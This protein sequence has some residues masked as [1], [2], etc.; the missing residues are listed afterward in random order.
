MKTTP[1]I[2]TKCPR[3]SGKKFKNCHGNKNNPSA[4][5]MKFE[6]KD[7]L[8]KKG[9][10][11]W[12]NGVYLFGDLFDANENYPFR[13]FV[14]PLEN[15]AWRLAELNWMRQFKHINNGVIAQALINKAAALLKT[16]NLWAGEQTQ[17]GA[18]V[19]INQKFVPDEAITS[20]TIS[21]RSGLLYMPLIQWNNLWDRIDQRI[22]AD[23]Y[24]RVHGFSKE[25]VKTAV[26]VLRNIFPSNWVRARYADASTTN[27][28]PRMGDA[29]PPEEKNSWFPAYHLA[30]TALGAICVDPGW[31]YLVE[32]GL[33]IKDL[34][35]FK[36]TKKILKNLTKSPG[37]QHHLCLAS[38]LYKRG[39]LIGL[40]PPTGSGNATNDLSISINENHYAVEV[41]EFT[42]RSPIHALIKELKDKSKKLPNTPSCPVVFHIVLREEGNKDVLKERE[43]FNS[44]ESIKSKIPSKISA[45]VAGS[46]F[47]DAM[48]GRVKRDTSKIILNPTSIQ[49][50]NIEDLEILFKKNYSEITYPCHGIGTFFYFENST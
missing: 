27:D 25:K 48:G 46:R 21:F 17:D 1:G 14:V 47:I 34:E 32:I 29:F 43:F 5:Q 41:K 45:I 8:F 31:N 28:P 9:V 2:N 3:E 10:D 11:S 12:D 7:I 26:K 22:L 44:L 37:T 6:F 42:S 24:F 39:Y 38:E 40:E 13:L 18:R 33:S 49:K 50:S 20:N 15:G 30:R 23:R 19:A 36:E 4:T 16:T 35:G